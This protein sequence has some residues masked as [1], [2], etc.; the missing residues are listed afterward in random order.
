MGYRKGGRW[1]KKGNAQRKDAPVR[2][3]SYPEVEPDN[4]TFKQYYK[5]QLQL[6]DE[7][8]DKMYQSLKEPLPSTFRITGTRSNAEQIRKFI[9]E[10]H[11]ANMQNIVVDD[12]KYDPPVPLP[13]YPDHLAWKIACPRSVLRKSPEYAS[14]QHFMV[15]ENETGNINRQEAVSMIPPLLMD[16]KPH[17]KV[18]D[19]CAAPGSKTAQIIEAVHGNDKYNELPAGLVVANDADY[20]RAQ[21]LVHQ[22]KRLQ[23]P[24]FLATNHDAS[25]FPNVSTKENG[26]ET[27]WQFD[28]VL[29][30]VPC[31]GDGTMRKNKK[32]WTSWSQ[33]G[34]LALHPLQVQIFL[35]GAQL[36]KM[37]GRIVYSTCSLNPIEN[38]AVVAE[39]L[40]L[41]EGCL[42]LKDVSLEL[43]ELIRRPGL[44]SWKVMTRDNQYIESVD[45]I[46]S[47]RVRY[48]FPKSAFPPKNAEELNLDR[49]LRIYPHDQDTG[50]FFV[51][52]FEKVKPMTAADRVV[53]AREKG[54]TLTKD[55][56]QAAEAQDASVVESVNVDSPSPSGDTPENDEVAIEDET[57]S[58]PKKRH[59]DLPEGVPKK[60]KQ[61][62]SAPKEAPFELID[63]T[64]E[65]V[66][67]VRT[68]FG[69]KEEFPL[70]QFLVRA[71]PG[72][73]YRNIY[74]VSQAVKDV[75]QSSDF[76]RLNMVN[77]GVRLF[78]RQGSL[79]DVNAC[80]FRLTTE[81]V[82]LIEPYLDDRRKLAVSMEDLK[83]LLVYAFPL[84]SQFTTAVRDA[85]ENFSPGGVLL[86]ID[87]EHTN[88]PA[89]TRLMIPVWKGKT[90]VNV[91]LNK[92][93]KKSFCMRLFDEIPEDIPDHI[94]ERGLVNQNK[95]TPEASTPNQTPAPQ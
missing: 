88:L 37:G 92:H 22:L 20:K 1:K 78:T 19:M 82:P 8:F 75:L 3:D 21:L 63:G 50:G 33:G 86:S 54:E 72:N 7:D 27:P 16:I 35:R 31:S 47:G 46:K 23:S 80:F 38:E 13:W 40:R 11:V 41:T 60:I 84:V 15:A 10:Q 26:V 59:S 91:L 29:C 55:D 89:A 57:S 83:V 25:Q 73:K 44:T 2:Y 93:D 56:I 14:F 28:R 77:T 58:V 48:K 17:Q 43:P 51:A 85:L 64:N 70:D 90:S 62:I 69:L 45:E 76:G 49:C 36:I 71:E 9:E 32:I 30:D 65:N 61:D 95:D 4:E 66:E 24:C 68:F 12:V 18:L 42:E 5:T 94:K 39:V 74:F 6:T 81:G 52:V 53:L 67:E 79:N 34:A 87:V